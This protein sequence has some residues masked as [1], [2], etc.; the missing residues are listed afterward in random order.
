VA[1]PDFDEELLE[2]W[3]EDGIV[4]PEEVAPGVVPAGVE[5]GV[6]AG[7]VPV[8]VVE[9]GV[10]PFKQEE[11]VEDCTLNGADWTEVPAES[12]KRRLRLVPL[13]TATGFQVYEVPVKLSHSKRAAPVGSAPG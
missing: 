9:V 8:P 3:L 4:L 11:E 7:V 13:A 6:V 12:R 1:V 2:L 5:A 10:V